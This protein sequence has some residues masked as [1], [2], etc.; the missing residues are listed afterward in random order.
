[1]HVEDLFEQLKAFD[2]ACKCNLCV[3][4]FAKALGKS[5][6][7]GCSWQGVCTVCDLQR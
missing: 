3:G 6:I 4:E 1:M 5:Y 2:K 7:K